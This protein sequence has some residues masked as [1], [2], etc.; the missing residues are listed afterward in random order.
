MMAGGMGLLGGGRYLLNKEDD[1]RAANTRA[2]LE[3]FLASS[4]I[5]QAQQMGILNQAQLN[6][7]NDSWLNLG[8]NARTQSLLDYAMQADSQYRELGAQQ[9]RAAQQRITDRGFTLSDQLDADYNRDLKVFGGVV[10]P[11]FQ[12]ALN[13]LDE[14]ATSADTVA[15]LYNFFNIIEPGGRVTENEDGMFQSIGGMPSQVSNWLNQIRGKG[16]DSETRRQILDAIWKQY[17][18]EYMRAK[19][20]R[21]QYQ[22]DIAAMRKQGY[23][24]RSPIGRLGINYDLNQIPEWATGGSKDQPPIPP[25]YREVDR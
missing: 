12:K 18:P 25:G 3:S 10:Q 2:G 5:P 21:D 20:Q 8:N 7:Q 11:A 17:Q 9:A 13:A 4:A 16:M 6:E 15:A 23:Q 1:R 24:V 19:R 14:G 22:R